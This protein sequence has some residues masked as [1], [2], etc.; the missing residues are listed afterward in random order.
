MFL[1]DFASYIFCDE[2]ILDKKIIHIYISNYRVQFMHIM[3]CKADNIRVML[4]PTLKYQGI[5][6]EPPRYMGDGFTVLQVMC[7]LLDANIL[8]LLP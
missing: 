1:Y 3:K 5:V 2:V 6:D 7:R 8:I 4:M